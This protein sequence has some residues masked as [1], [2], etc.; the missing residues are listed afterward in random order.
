MDSICVTFLRLNSYFFCFWR[1]LCAFQALMILETKLSS[2]TEETN[3]HQYNL[4]KDL[5]LAEFKFDPLWNIFDRWGHAS[6]L[7]P[8]RSI[9]SIFILEIRIRRSFS[10]SKFR[11]L[12]AKLPY[13]F[14][15]QQ[16][17]Q[18]NG[19]QIHHIP[20][21]QLVYPLFILLFVVFSEFSYIR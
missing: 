5:I 14:K 4:F 19:L 12:H 20:N 18:V 9:N 6:V 10:Y 16:L 21:V 11:W 8:Q 15:L 7:N 2:Q 1:V 3:S 17:I 13:T